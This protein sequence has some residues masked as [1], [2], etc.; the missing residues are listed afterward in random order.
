MAHR[1]KD[2]ATIPHISKV[3]TVTVPVVDFSLSD[4]REWFP[5]GTGN[6]CILNAGLIDTE[7]DTSTWRV[8]FPL[9]QGISNLVSG[10]REK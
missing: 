1:G 5:I 2:D 4:G 7:K 9:E 10:R 3:T 8:L 6:Q